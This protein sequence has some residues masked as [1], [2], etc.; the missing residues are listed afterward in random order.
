MP[1]GLKATSS[2]IQVSATVQEPGPNTF[3]S[4]ELQLTLN[5]LDNE[6]FVIT[7]LNI[8]VDAPDSVTATTTQSNA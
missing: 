4:E 3:V 1:K 7:Q 5:V 2:P 8:D 6:V